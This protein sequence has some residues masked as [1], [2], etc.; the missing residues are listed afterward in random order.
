MPVVPGK[1][2]VY[3][4]ILPPPEVAEQ[5]LRLITAARGRH[6]L[7]AKPTPPDRL[8]V[9]LNYIGDFKRP[10]GPVIDKAAEAARPVAARPFTVAFNRFGSWGLGGKG[11]PIVL[12]GDDGVI[13]VDD[14]Y[15]SIHRALVKPGMVPRREVEMTP[16]M[17]LIRDKAHIP[18]TFVDPVSWTVDE[19]VLIYAIHGEGRYEVVERYPLNG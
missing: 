13:G 6:G 12:W 10:C 17:T 4:A 5:A 16:H 9:S 14:L 18:E 7:T 15:S 19:F 8:H 2:V 11:G 3:F 1:H